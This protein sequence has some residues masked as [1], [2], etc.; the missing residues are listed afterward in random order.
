MLVFEIWKQK[1]KKK[2]MIQT[3][4][5]N[6]SLQGINVCCMYARAIFYIVYVDWMYV[7][8]VMYVKNEKKKINDKYVC[9]R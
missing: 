7:Q 3:I 6:N 5:N 4:R 2:Q 1:G 8:V 9:L